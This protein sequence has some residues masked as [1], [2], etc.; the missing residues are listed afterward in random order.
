MSET[1]ADAMGA[2]GVFVGILQYVGLYIQLN[3][4]GGGE[5]DNHISGNGK[6]SLDG[7]CWRGLERQ[8]KLLKNIKLAPGNVLC[9]VQGMPRYIWFVVMFS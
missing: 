1:A 8:E 4:A 5:L 2:F 3:A 7:G 6:L 9:W